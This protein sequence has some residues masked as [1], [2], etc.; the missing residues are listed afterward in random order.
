MCVC[1]CYTRECKRLKMKVEDL[2]EQAR[3]VQLLR[4][5]KDLQLSLSE[6][7][8]GGRDQHDIET[9]EKTLEL[10]ERVGYSC[11]VSRLSMVITYRHTRRRPGRR[12][13]SWPG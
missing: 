5:T 12:R 11:Y 4:V 7:G 9:L 8:S 13:S 1:V 3:E 10:N 6:E 2:Q